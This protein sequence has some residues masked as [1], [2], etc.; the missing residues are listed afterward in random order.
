MHIDPRTYPETQTPGEEELIVL[1]ADRHH[2]DTED[3]KNATSCE[4]IAITARDT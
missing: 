4:L 1:G 3:P 2:E